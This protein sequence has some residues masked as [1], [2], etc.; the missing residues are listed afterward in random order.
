M[1]DLY[2][3]RPWHV[4]GSPAIPRLRDPGDPIKLLTTLC[5]VGTCKALTCE[6]G[7]Q[8]GR[9]PHASQAGMCA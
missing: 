9:P 4:A 1:S 6:G 2:V 7:P 8:G 5:R 3:R